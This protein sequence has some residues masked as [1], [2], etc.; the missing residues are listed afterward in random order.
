MNVLLSRARWKMVLVG[1]FGFLRSVISPLPDD[2]DGPFEFLKKLMIVLDEGLANK[3]I[4]RI[5]GSML[6]EGFKK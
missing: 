5:S 3:K 1:S 4:G 6:S 2:P